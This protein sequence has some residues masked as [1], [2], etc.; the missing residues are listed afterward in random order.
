MFQNRGKR[1]YK[2]GVTLQLRDINRYYMWLENLV[3]RSA[4]YRIR[5]RQDR[6]TSFRRRFDKFSTAQF[7]VGYSTSGEKL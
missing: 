6:F 5:A 2:T 3:M 7:F 1:A 4:D